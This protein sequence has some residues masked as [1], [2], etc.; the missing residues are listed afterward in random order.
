MLAYQM[1]HEEVIRILEQHILKNP[2]V[3]THEHFQGMM[4][5]REIGQVV[6]FCK[7]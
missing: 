6:F 7:Y 3:Y 1:H 2:H 5:S 4:K